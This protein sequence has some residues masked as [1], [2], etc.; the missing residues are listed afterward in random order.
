MTTPDDDDVRLTPEE[1]QA[2]REAGKKLFG[3]PQP[4]RPTA[5]ERALAQ[6][7]RLKGALEDGP[8]AQ[9]Y[10]NALPESEGPLPVLTRM[11]ARI[12]LDE[13]TELRILT[14]VYLNEPLPAEEA[15]ALWA[16]YNHA[17]KR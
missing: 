16:A 15:A 12:P 5:H 17:V 9:T 3:R 6:V 13:A 1:D 8:P 7:E 10:S 11:S 4:P 2:A 14:H